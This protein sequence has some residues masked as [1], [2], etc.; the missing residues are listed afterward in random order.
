MKMLILALLC[1]RAVIVW[2]AISAGRGSEAEEPSEMR[3]S[4]GPTVTPWNQT[5]APRNNIRPAVSLDWAM[6]FSVDSRSNDMQLQNYLPQRV[7]WPPPRARR[8]VHSNDQT[9]KFQRWHRQL[10]SSYNL[11]LRQSRTESTPSVHPRMFVSTWLSI[12][13][14]RHKPRFPV[15]VPTSSLDNS[16]L[17]YAVPVTSA[18]ELK[19]GIRLPRGHPGIF[20]NRDPYLNF[21]GATGLVLRKSIPL[22]HGRPSMLWF[23]DLRRHQSFC[24]GA[25]KPSRSSF[26]AKNLKSPMSGV[27]APVGLEEGNAGA[28]FP[29]WVHRTLSAAQYDVYLQLGI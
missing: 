9:K 25:K 7:H 11:L 13:V 6:S 15:P 21:S 19:S 16:H 29:G 5:S 2:S 4:I 17:F 26:G 23:K 12:C 20:C 28:I 8:G 18:P 22:T 1:L 10:A 3:R 24:S 14:A 27:N